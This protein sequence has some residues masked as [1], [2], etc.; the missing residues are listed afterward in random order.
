MACKERVLAAQC[1]G[2]DAAF[3]DIA[4][5]LDGAVGEKDLQPCHV[6]YDLAE[7]LAKARFSRNAGT[8][9]FGPDFEAINQW[10]GMKL[11][12]IFAVFGRLPTYLGFSFIELRDAAQ[13]FCGNW[14]AI[15]IMDFLEL[16][17]G[18]RPAIGQCHRPT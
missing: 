16:A 3:H 18:V 6:L 4:V 12:R 10:L 7:L 1:N 2:A 8:L 13:P 9:C 5:H 17:S 15:P 11:S 14:R